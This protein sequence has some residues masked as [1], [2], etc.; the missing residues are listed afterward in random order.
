MSKRV[1]ILKVDWIIVSN[2]AIGGAFTN[3][4]EDILPIIDLPTPLLTFAP[5]FLYCSAGKSAYC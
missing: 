3:Y 2:I 1:L 5:E 4:V